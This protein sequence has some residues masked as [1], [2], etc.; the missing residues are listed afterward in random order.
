MDNILIACEATHYIKQRK[1]GKVVYAVIKLNMSKAYDRVEWQFLRGMMMK[2]GFD[3]RWVALIM[4]CVST[5]K[6]N[7]RVNGELTNE[8]T[9][10]RGLR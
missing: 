2:L 5:V 1:K 10:E 8:F 7:I 3:Q 9:P 4:K 6:Y